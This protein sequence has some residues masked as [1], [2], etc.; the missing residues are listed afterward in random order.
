MPSNITCV[1]ID[2][3]PKMC[4]LLAELVKDLYPDIEISATYTNWKPALEHLR[5][6]EPDILFTDI[7]MP[8]KTGFDL[9]ELLPNL[10]SEIIFVTAHTEFALDAF[11]FDVCGYVLK[12]VN[13]K[14]LVK[15]VDRAINRIKAKKPGESSTNINQQKIGVPD[16]S[17]IHYVNLN[18]IIYCESQNRYTKVVTTE[19][20]IL[21]SYNIGKFQ[22]TLHDEQFYQLH[23]SYVINLNHVKKYDSSGLVIMKDNTEIP[24]SRKHKD[25]FLAKFNRVKK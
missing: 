2:D 19:N 13:D 14:I 18:D 4:D 9:L 6:A 8:G 23:R 16:A 5:N 25:E 21:S 12:P 11:N 24:V 15:T 10:N 17:G 3:E 1:I 22:D 20:E 7:S